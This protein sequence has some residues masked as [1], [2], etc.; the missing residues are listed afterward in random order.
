MIGHLPAT[1]IAA[2]VGAGA[3]VILGLVGLGLIGPA[4]LHTPMLAFIAIFIFFA[5]QQEL[6]M[7]RHR[8]AIRREPIADVLPAEHDDI[9]RVVPVRPEPFSGLVWND[10]DRVWVVWRN[11]RPV[12]SF[13]GE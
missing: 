9:P 12:H 11:G 3:A 5:G 13:Q 10:R 4:E 7:I 6:A 1:E 2:K 8:E